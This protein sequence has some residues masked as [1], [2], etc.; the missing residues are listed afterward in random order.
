MKKYLFLFVVCVAAMLPA[1]KMCVWH[2]GTSTEF[3]I[4]R[5]DSITFTGFLSDPLLGVF[6]V[7][8]TTRVRFAAGNLQYTQSADT[9]SFAAQQYEFVGEKNIQDDR[10]ADRIDLFG[11]SGLTGAAKWGISISQN[12]AD[13]DGDNGGFVD[14]GMNLGDGTT[15]RTL[16]SAEWEYIV[17]E[18]P[19]AG[20]LN[21]IACIRLNDAGTEFANGLILLPDGWQAPNGVTVKSGGA[22]GLGTEAYAAHQT[23][24]LSQWRQLES[25]GAVFLPA[26][27]DRYGL[28]VDFVQTDGYYWSATPYGS[29][30]AC[31]FHFNLAGGYADC[32]FVRHIGRA[33]RLV[34]NVP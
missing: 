26:A 1:Q 25:A 15:W 14:W 30:N 29:H 24:T 27:G 21:A 16:T 31:L 18:R 5:V 10:L 4:T 28:I 32:D 12:D 9:W 7:S 17:R 13:Y 3:A 8:P 33:V 34:Q 23:F 2:D 20:S 11:W 6:S 19:D 22:R